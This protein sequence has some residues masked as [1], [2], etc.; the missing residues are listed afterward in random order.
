MKFHNF[1]RH[2]ERGGRGVLAEDTSGSSAKPQRSPRSRLLWV[3]GALWV[4]GCDRTTNEVT[5][6]AR[7]SAGIRIVE[8][9][10]EPSTVPE[11]TLDSVPLRVLTGMETG[12]ETAF[13]FVGPVRFL[14]SGGV[15][16]A[17][18]ASSRLLIYDA[19]GG[20]ARPL[21]RR[22]DGP[23]ELRRLE[24]ITVDQNGTIA[25]FDPSLR[26]LSFWNPDSG[27]V[28]SISVADGGS[29][30]SWPADAA[31]WLDS[32]LI[33]FQLAATPQDS[34][35][36]GSGVRRW[37]VRAHLTLRDSLTGIRKVS[38][39]FAGMY[40]GLD[41]RG[42]L[43]LPFSNRPFVALAKDRVYFGSGDSFQVMYLD[44]AFNRAGEIRWPARDE[45]LT[46]DEVEQVRAEAIALVSRRPLPDNL[47]AKHFATEILP[48]NRPSIGRVFV[49]GEGR[50]WI[51]RFEAIRMGT[52]TQKPGDQWS[53]LSEDGVPLAILRLPASTR[54]E[55]VRGEDVVVVRRDSLD[56]QTV[57]IYR[58]KR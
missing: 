40:S 16:V 38:P 24:S 47:F 29:L 8:V 18:V 6:V 31:P 41:E 32:Q 53:I 22:G 27:F 36:A 5:T 56:V 33:V 28:R 43:R 39:T 2:F 45:R 52:A 7:D 14:P 51:E 44:T 17:D 57:V 35:P 50:L 11:W 37:Q 30:E 42:N 54:L 46:S 10:A 49:D 34:V 26:R 9:L 23:G 13:A 25:T 21:G 3:V 4:G 15:V 12:D 48:T 55:D 1:E 58:L 20:Y 19:G